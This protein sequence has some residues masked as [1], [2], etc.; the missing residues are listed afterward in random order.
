MSNKSKK[1]FIFF[2][3]RDFSKHGGGSLRMKG[4]LN[5]LSK[6]GA[7][8]I[9]ISN[10]PT[11]IGFHSAIK[12]IP[13][14]VYFDKKEKQI[15]Q[16]LLGLFPLFVVNF[17][18]SSKL[19]QLRNFLTKNNFYGRELIFF[20]Y[21]DNSIAYFLKKNKVISSYTNDIHGIV[22][23]E[24]KE[25]KSSG[26]LKSMLMYIKYIA[27]RK[28]DDKVFNFADSLIFVSE[29]MKKH[30]YSLYPKI[31]DKENYI[32]HDAI[33]KDFCEQKVDQ[34]LLEKIKIQYKIEDQEQIV[35]F[36]GAF[37]DLGG[38]MDLVQAFIL[39]CKKRS[40]VKL[41][42]IGGGEYLEKAKELVEKEKAEDKVIFVGMV[43]YEKLKT[44][45]HVADIIVCPDK[46]HPYSDKVIH[47]KYFD[48]LASG[49]IV[50]NGSFD[51]I[52]EINKNQELSVNFEPS[53]INDLSDKLVYCLENIGELT[54]KYKD[55]REQVCSK[56]LYENNIEDFCEERFCD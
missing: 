21:L 1:Q 24:F 7:D 55:I 53:N 44:Y 34:K 45:Q 46:K 30:F 22:P 6:R 5:A 33:S 36:A 12:H 39:T 43:P 18:F 38:V 28:L 31:R 49:K 11:H 42:L 29:S 20:E 14:D 15:F 13:L 37:K 23:L 16:L 10:T 8:V 25:T 56:Y 17:I 4:I 51:S 54:I 9:L 27:A 52:Q 50:I 3:F 19:N 32:M 2:T 40:N 35:F 26:I 47:I 41:F 48:S